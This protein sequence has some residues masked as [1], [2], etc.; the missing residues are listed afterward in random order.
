MF[1]IAG[2]LASFSLFAPCRMLQALKRCCHLVEHKKLCSFTGKKNTNLP[3]LYFLPKWKEQSCASGGKGLMGWGCAGKE[4]ELECPHLHCSFSERSKMSLIFFFY[5][6][7]PVLNFFLSFFPKDQ[8]SAHCLASKACNFHKVPWISWKKQ[9]ERCS[10]F[11]ALWSRVLVQE[12][13]PVTQG[14]LLSGFWSHTSLW[15]S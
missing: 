12:K 11:C 14:R 10:G 9:E 2:K 15:E 6:P 8:S 5:F 3:S 4:L 13:L 7:S 1:E